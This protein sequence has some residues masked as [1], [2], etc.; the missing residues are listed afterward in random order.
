MVPPDIGWPKAVAANARAMAL[1]DTLSEVHVNAG[2]INMVYLRDFVAAEKE[3]AQA[4][5][6]NSRFQEAHLIYSFFLLTRSRFNEAISEA[7]LSLELDPFSPRLVSNLGLIYL[8]ARQYPE[9]V[10]AYRRAV[11]LDPRNPLVHDSLADALLCSGM[12]SDAFNE[13]KIAFEC[14]GD[15]S[16][17]EQVTRSATK[18]NIE[19]TLKLV[20]NLKLPHL[21][22]KRAR[23]EYV[24]EIHFVRG[25]AAAGDLEGALSHLG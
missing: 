5:A 21:D 13:W 24:P 17:A 6:L 3:M 12:E 9:A 4:L 15:S 20:A 2:G 22:A 10:S 25:L 23:G 7:K 8:F 11:E 16:A 1:D 19:K 14:M 18:T